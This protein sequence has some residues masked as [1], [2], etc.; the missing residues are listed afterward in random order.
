MKI[1]L[2]LSLL[3]SSQALALSCSKPVTLS[4]PG[5]DAND[6][7]LIAINEKGDAVVFW[8]TSQEDGEKIYAATRIPEKTWTEPAALG[9]EEIV[10]KG[11]SFIDSEGCISACWEVEKQNQIFYK[12]VQKKQGMAWSPLLDVLGPEDNIISPQAAFRPDNQVIFLGTHPASLQARVLH[13]FPS[14]EKIFHNLSDISIYHHNSHLITN[15]QG[16]VFAC[17]L[18]DQSEN[19]KHFGLQGAWLL[20]GQTW[21]PSTDIINIF[22]ANGK[23]EHV[24]SVKAVMNGSGDLAFIVQNN[25]FETAQKTLL[26]ILY[27]DSQWSAPMNMGGSRAEFYNAEIA[28]DDQGNVLAAWYAFENGKMV[29]FAAY[30]PQG[31]AWITPVSLSYPTKDVSDLKLGIDHVGNFI[32]LWE[33]SQ[34]IIQGAVFSTTTQQWSNATLSPLQQKCTSP[35]FV[36][37]SKGKGI[38]TW[39]I[40]EEERDAI[41][42]AEL[43]ID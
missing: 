10:W 37:N 33:E 2:S 15:K 12:C 4:L 26:V 13:Y 42:V 5:Q 16:K 20:E 21:S 32:L 40:T 34:K 36:F 38:V 27:T 31:Q 7:E 39:T 35:S 8:L 30:K 6:L 3:L 9:V 23:Y 28:L 14:G 17:W 1:I 22:Y 19:K 25:D 41:Q 29:V 24:D 18:K 43:N 11:E